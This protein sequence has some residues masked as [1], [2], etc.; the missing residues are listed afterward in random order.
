MFQGVFRRNW[1]VFT[2]SLVISTS[3]FASSAWGLAK[4]FLQLELPAFIGATNTENP[5]ECERIITCLLAREMARV[6]F[7][8]ALQSSPDFDGQTI[9]SLS[10]VERLFEVPLASLS[11]SQGTGLA[12]EPAATVERV[13]PLQSGVLALTFATEVR[14][15]EE[16]IA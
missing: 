10:L 4:P 1:W 15:G 11:R 2:T 7:E 8:T 16:A 9:A 3:V 12:H 6:R 14:M 5:R 13:Q